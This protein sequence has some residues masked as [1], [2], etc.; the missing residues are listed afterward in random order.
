VKRRF[1]A[2]LFAA[3]LITS[4]PSF[5]DAPAGA[6]PSPDFVTIGSV[7]PPGENGT[8]TLDPETQGV[9]FGPHFT[10]Q[11]AMYADL[12]HHDAITESEIPQFFKDAGFNTVVDPADVERIEIVGPGVRIFRDTFGVAHVYGEAAD[13]VAYGAGYV[14]AE[15]RMFEADIFRHAARGTLSEILGDAYISYDEATRREGYTEAELQQQIT[16]LPSK[17]GADGVRVAHGIE[18]FS[19]GFN[20]RVAEVLADPSQLPVEYIGTGTLPAPWRPTDTVAESVLLS[21]Q[22]G[23]AAGAGE[24]RNAALLQAL[25]A[26]L[27]NEADARKAFDDLR[28]LNDPAAATTVPASDGL[29]TFPSTGAPDESATA[30]PDHAAAIW[31]GQVRERTRLSRL[32]SGLELGHPSSNAMLI[33]TTESATGNPLQLGDPQVEYAVPQYLMELSLHGGGYEAAG[34][35]FPGVSGFVLIGH[36]TDYAWTVTSGISDA[37]DV[38]AERLC[39]PDPYTAVTTESDHY[40]F[41]GQCL[42]MES[43]EE[44][45]LSKDTDPRKLPDNQRPEV[46]VL[47]VQRT[48]HGPVFARDTVNGVPVALV[49]ERDFWMREFDNAAAFGSF[50]FP[51]HVHNATEFGAAASNIVVSLNLYYADHDSI[52]YWHTGKYPLR[53]AGVETRLPTWGTGEWEWGGDLAFV[54]QPHYISTRTAQSAGR[55]YTYNWNNK[56]AVGWANGDDTNWGEIHRVDALKIAMDAA[57]AGG[58]TMSRL[59][60]INIMNSAATADPRVPKLLPLLTAQTDTGAD[61]RLSHAL[62]LMAAWAAAGPAPGAHLLDRDHDDTYDAS[63]AIAVWN[64]WNERLVQDLFY[65][66][67]GGTARANLG[68]TTVDAPGAGGSAFFDG[69]FNHALHVMDPSATLQPQF[70]WLNGAT[71]THIA[72]TALIEALDGLGATTN[73]AVDAL[74]VGAAKIVFASLGASDPIEIPWV[75]RGTWT[76]VAEVTG[77]REVDPFPAL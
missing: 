44:I 63:P 17:F 70:D 71:R 13:A 66:R 32:L 75:N 54:Q 20:Q 10:D 68:V 6:L 52:A 73:A 23:E 9:V 3:V 5:G 55:D 11:L 29:F 15:D 26:Q 59:D 58:G 53:H 35:T 21:R 72:T 37:V 51:D 76:H 74:T 27:G 57:L 34:M 25:R 43:R 18:A 62:G 60:V 7:L 30:L 4:V 56:P 36:S 39:E 28:W 67:I 77:R 42:A 49:K 31:D 19:E 41:N 65:G 45:I 2:L 50:N 46:V 40:L 47:D 48:R 69:M 38:R 64:A 8:A 24:I 33:G 16:A 1:A 22:F 14:T 61:Q 12:V